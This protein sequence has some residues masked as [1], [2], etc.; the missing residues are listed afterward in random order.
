MTFSMSVGFVK[1]TFLFSKYRNPEVQI[2]YFS[3]SPFSK[4]I[5]NKVELVENV[6]IS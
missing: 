5:D 1:D 2:V 3:F 6:D 4:I